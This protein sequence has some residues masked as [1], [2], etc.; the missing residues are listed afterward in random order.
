MCGSDV[1]SETAAG[2]LSPMLGE[3]A[4]RGEAGATGFADSDCDV[5][6]E[7]SAARNIVGNDNPLQEAARHMLANVSP[8]RVLFLRDSLRSW[9]QRGPMRI[10]TAFTGCDIV[11]KVLSILFAEFRMQLDVPCNFVMAFGCESVPSKRQWLMQQFPDLPILFDD[12]EAL[13][14]VAAINTLTKKQEI[15]PHVDLF[16]AGFTCTSRSPSNKS[17]S[18]N[19]GCIK[20]GSDKSGE[21][22]HKLKVYIMNKRPPCVLLENI[23]PL[24]QWGHV[25]RLQ[26]DQ[27]V[28]RDDR[29]LLLPL[30]CVGRRLR[31]LYRPQALVVHRI[32]APPNRRVEIGWSI[33][34]FDL[35][36][37]RNVGRDE[38]R[39]L[40]H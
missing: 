6:G 1:V 28:V 40:R 21:A 23:T 13:G 35:R 12:V 5:A 22:F 36:D 24:C 11:C 18:H 10:G 37:E 7:A 34:C 14:A 20:Q 19:K 9:A 8:A 25:V 27:G 17:A 26:L 30:H 2:D 4:G 15:V 29:L 3:S 39:S 33:S 31:Q 38:D 16:T 32:S